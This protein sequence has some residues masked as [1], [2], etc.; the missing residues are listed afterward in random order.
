[1]YLTYGNKVFTK[2]QL[3]FLSRLYT[4]S[5]SFSP[6]II[7]KKSTVALIFKKSICNLNTGTETLQ[8]IWCRNH[9]CNVFKNR[10]HMTFLSDG[11]WSPVRPSV[12]FTTKMDGTLDIWDFL[13]KQNDP[14]LTLK[15][16]YPNSNQSYLLSQKYQTLLFLLLLLYFE[17]F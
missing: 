15:V 5:F 17:L 16:C 4:F 11:C 1:M 13:F 14:A 12:F 2:S 3:C 8:C 10:Y 6:Q 7:R 9:F